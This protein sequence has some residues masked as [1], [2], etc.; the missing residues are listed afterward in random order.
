MLAWPRRE[1]ELLPFA[2]CCAGL[3]KY[4]SAPSHKCKHKRERSSNDRHQ[5]LQIAVMQVIFT[6]KALKCG[7]HAEKGDGDRNG[8]DRK[9]SSFGL[10]F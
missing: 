3:C 9:V 8:T 1:V 2:A 4:D 10:L 5:R 6:E 7:L